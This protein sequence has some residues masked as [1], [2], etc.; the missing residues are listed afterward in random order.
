VKILLYAQNAKMARLDLIAVK[1]NFMQI[2]GASERILRN[3]TTEFVVR[4]PDAN[5]MQRSSLAVASSDVNRI[6]ACS[7]I[8]ESTLSLSLV[9]VL[10]VACVCM[11]PCVCVYL[12]VYVSLY[13]HEYTCV[14]TSVFLLFFNR[15]TPPHK[16]MQM[17]GEEA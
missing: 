10:I 8:V 12:H 4:R 16:H 17:G 6:E 11:W 1:R 7:S 13:L 9:S 15:A 14:Y 5:M 2:K 3:N